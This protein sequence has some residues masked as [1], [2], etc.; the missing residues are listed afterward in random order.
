MKMQN[1]KDGI[2]GISVGGE[3]IGFESKQ[4]KLDFLYSLPIASGPMGS[5]CANDL[6]KEERVRLGAREFLLCVIFKECFK[7]KFGQSGDDAD[8]TM[9]DA[10]DMRNEAWDENSDHYI[11]GY[12][13]RFCKK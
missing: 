5:V 2:L 3:Y 9:K 11:E 7:D 6:I 10:I 12:R 1:E 8:Q 13:E 4:A